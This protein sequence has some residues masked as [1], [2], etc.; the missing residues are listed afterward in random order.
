MKSID[1]LGTW[2]AQ[3]RLASQAEHGEDTL[4]DLLDRFGAIITS[5]R[6]DFE[7][8][9]LDST[10]LKELARLHKAKLRRQLDYRLEVLDDVMAMAGR[11]VA[12]ADK[13]AEQSTVTTSERKRQQDKP[14]TIWLDANIH[15]YKGHG[16]IK[17]AI[18]DYL[19]EK[20]TGESVEQLRTEY[21]NDLR[22][23][24]KQN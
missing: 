6:I 8:Q 2:M 9:G 20:E 4:H 11:L 10:E 15:R 16:R 5:L 24:K 21:N 7:L 12:H 14:I 17:R 23:R 22:R 13:V 19:Q 1:D 3:W 18:E